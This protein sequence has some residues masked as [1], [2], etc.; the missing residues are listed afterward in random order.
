MKTLFVKLI[1]LCMLVATISSCKKDEDKIVATKSTPANLN[2]SASTLVLTKATQANKA[3]TFTITNP[4]FGYNAVVTN[5]I[6]V[7]VKDSNF[8]KFSEATFDTKAAT[9]E[10]TV[11]ELNKLVLALN[12][13]T[14]VPS[15]F[16]VRIKSSISDQY[17]PVYSNVLTLRITPYSSIEWAYVPGAYQG[18]DP[19]SADSLVSLAGN[20]VYTG[21]IKFTPSNLGFKILTKKL[22]GPPEYGKGSSDGTLAI[23]GGDLA[24]PA[25]GSHKLTADL[26]ALTLT[27]APYSFGIIGSAT[28]TGWDSDSDM[29]YNNGTRTWSITIPLTAGAIKFRLNDDWGT[30]YGGSG[31]ALAS[32]GSDINIPASGNYKVEFSLETNTYTLTKL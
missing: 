22:W 26:N 18:W 4:D 16:E 31:G 32:G 20:G 17:A 25:A 23:G 12:V 29:A 8:T 24:A 14:E 21:I 10:L 1:T 9:K 5:T 11:A 30:N 19:A 7:A 2:A 27:I 15:N 6:Q 13:P 28:P 3:L